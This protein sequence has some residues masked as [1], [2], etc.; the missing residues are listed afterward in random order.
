MSSWRAWNRSDGPAKT[1]VAA[2]SA[3]KRDALCLDWVDCFERHRKDRQ[4]SVLRPYLLVIG[5]LR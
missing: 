4:V 1:G 5:R 3:A 2:L